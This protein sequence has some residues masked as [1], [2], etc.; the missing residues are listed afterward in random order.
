MAAQAV[1]T[2]EMADSRGDDLERG[3]EGP[4]DGDDQRAIVVGYPT[5]LAAMLARADSTLVD[6]L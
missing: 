3:G 2:N 6:A 1:L 5:G 4:I